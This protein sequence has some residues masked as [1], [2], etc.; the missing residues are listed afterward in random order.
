MPPKKNTHIDTVFGLST[1]KRFPM[2]FGLQPEP[3]C[4]V[5]ESL[6]FKLNVKFNCD[7]II[8]V[9]WIAHSEIS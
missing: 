1:S 4:P 6:F 7:A 5:S 2:A 3:N 8:L 9:A